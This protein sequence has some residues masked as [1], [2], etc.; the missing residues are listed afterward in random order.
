MKIKVKSYIFIK[1][2]FLSERDSLVDAITT[3][4]AAYDAGTDV[5]SLNPCNIQRGTLVNELYRQH[6]FS[7][8]WLWSVLI[9]VKAAKSLASNLKIIC[10]PTAGGKPRGAH[11]CGK[12]DKQILEYIQLLT[13]DKEIPLNLNEVCECFLNWELILNSPW[14][15]LR[16]RNHPN[17]K[18]LNPLSE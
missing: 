1:S 18:K 10:E 5:I 8:P 15:I 4:K 3:I 11:N 7:P 17:L 13:E 2:P 12:C 14:E 16:I 9:A 6:L